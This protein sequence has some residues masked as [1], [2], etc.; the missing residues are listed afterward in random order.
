MNVLK[1][2]KGAS[3][4]EGPKDLSSGMDSHNSSLSSRR[5]TESKEGEAPGLEEKL[6]YARYTAA[7]R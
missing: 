7:C 6:A 2:L 3:E 5:S 4:Q 1:N